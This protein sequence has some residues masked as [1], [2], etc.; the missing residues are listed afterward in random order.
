[1]RVATE[2]IIKTLR[3]TLAGAQSK[4][5]ALLDAVADLTKE[6]QALESRVIELESELTQAQNQAAEAREVMEMCA[7]PPA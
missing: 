5:L 7:R 1:M 3:E 6:N 4:E 2:F